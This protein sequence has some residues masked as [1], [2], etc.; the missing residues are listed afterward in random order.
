M[1]PFDSVFNL[2][3]NWLLNALQA[4]LELAG[5][6]VPLGSSAQH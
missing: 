2:I 5:K 1:T 4:S 6:R 3:L